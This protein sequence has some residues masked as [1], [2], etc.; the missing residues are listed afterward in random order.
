[1]AGTGGEGER[2]SSTG[3]CKC[4][5]TKSTPANL[6]EGIQA[7]REALGEHRCRG[8]ANDVFASN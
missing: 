4:D 8:G 2:R 3:P 6:W 1:M 7:Q 5:A